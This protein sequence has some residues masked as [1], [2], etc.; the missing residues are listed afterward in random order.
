MLKR[1]LYVSIFAFLFGTS[2]SA[3][4][5]NITDYYTYGVSYF[6]KG[7]YQNARVAF[8]TF[9]KNYP[10]NEN[11]R[12]YLAQCYIRLNKIGDART[13]YNKIIMQNKKQRHLCFLFCF[14]LSFF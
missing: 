4:L 6:Q 12:Y 9:L 5:T 3:A 14:L 10:N 7:D 13:E 2:V 11:A 1:V 8:E